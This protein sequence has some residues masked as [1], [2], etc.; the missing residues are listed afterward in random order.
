MIENL[1]KA[2]NLKN[3]TPELVEKKDPPIIIR[4]RKIKLK[5]LGTFNEIP[6]FE[7]ELHIASN[8][9]VK[10]LSKLKKTKKTEIINI[11]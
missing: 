4:I 6:I 5:L 7:I 10:L 1:N 3:L 2:N 11:K 8:N 9:E